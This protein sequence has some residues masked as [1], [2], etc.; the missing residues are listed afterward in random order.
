[1]AVCTKCGGRKTT[2]LPIRAG[3]LGWAGV[4]VACSECKGSGETPST[5]NKCGGSKKTYLTMRG[6]AMEVP[7][8][9][10]A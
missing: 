8:P 3:T 2:N 10:C 5:C 6:G 1:M 9:A 7:C 4:E